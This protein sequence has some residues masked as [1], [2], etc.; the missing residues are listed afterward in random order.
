MKKI[1]FI[2]YLRAIAIIFV[3]IWHIYISFWIN[4]QSLTISI[5]AKPIYNFSDII[6]FEFFKKYPISLGTIGV[7]IFFLISAFITPYSLNKKKINV[8]I[9]LRIFKIYP[10]YFV[11]LLISILILWLNSN[12]YNTKFILPTSRL[13]ANIFLVQDWLYVPF[14]DTGTWFLLV[15]LKFY[16]LIIIIKNF[17]QSLYYSFYIILLIIILILSI[18][19]NYFVQFF[20][21]SIFYGIFFTF[22]YSTIEISYMFIGLFIYY[23]YNKIWSKKTTFLVITLYYLCFF[24]MVNYSH[25]E[26]N[27]LHYVINYNLGL[28]I[29]YIFFS[30]RKYLSSIILINN[31]AKIS[32]SWFLVHRIF[33]YFIMLILLRFKINYVVITF[34]SIQ[35]T[36]LLASLLY[37][38]IERPIYRFIKRNL[39]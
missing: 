39:Y 34:I 1:L 38:F 37:Y 3:I 10:A 12:I 11:S 14:I 35:L 17:K 7:A 16:F 23:G 2:E 9:L 5:N 29:F 33:G 13:I 22:A 28:A 25:I 31:I 8:F 32:Y 4:Y 6:L 21:S 36:F 18:L 24:I 15:I 26:T 27:I 19:S 30:L 20:Y